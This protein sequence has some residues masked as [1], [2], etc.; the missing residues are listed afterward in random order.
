MFGGHAG[1]IVGYITEV[2]VLS[3]IQFTARLVTA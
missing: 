1:L 3:L 2:I